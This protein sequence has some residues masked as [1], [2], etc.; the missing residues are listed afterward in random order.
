VRLKCERCDAVME[1]QLELEGE[2]DA[3]EKALTGCEAELEAAIAGQNIAI[4][5]SSQFE[6]LNQQLSHAHSQ[7]YTE[8]MNKHEGVMAE[9]ARLRSALE[10]IADPRKRDHR[11]PDAYTELGCVMH[12][13]EQALEPKGSE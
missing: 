13:A 8:L 5:T 3:F 6:K 11:E 9:N 2:V 12:I 1:R 10:K 7:R 4:E